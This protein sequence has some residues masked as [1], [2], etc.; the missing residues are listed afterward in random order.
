[1]GSEVPLNAGDGA[2][3][4]SQLHVAISCSAILQ[5]CNRYGEQ[6]APGKIKRQTKKRK[7]AANYRNVLQAKWELW[8]TFILGE[9]KK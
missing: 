2:I 8:Q 5:V 9:Q 4:T 1:M 6:N 7:W 3:F